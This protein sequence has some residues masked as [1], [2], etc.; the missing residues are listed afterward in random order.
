MPLERWRPGQRIRDQQ[1]IPIFAG[2]PP[3]VYT[4]YVGAFRGD[5]RLPV[6]PP[7]LSDGKD[8]LGCSQ[9]WSVRR[10][11]DRLGAALSSK[12]AG[13]LA[14]LSI[15]LLALV[16]TAVALIA[17]VR[18]PTTADWQEAAR[19][20]RA[21]FRPGDLVVAAP[22]WADQILRLHLGDLIPDD[23]AGRLDDDRFGRVW[24]ISQRGATAPAARRGA[25]VYERDAGRLTVRRVERTPETVDYDFVA[26]WADAQVIRRGAVG[27]AVACSNAGD[28]IQCPDVGYNFVRRQIVEVDT[29]LRVALLAQP[30]PNA[31]VVI[32][33]PQVPL[34]RVLV[35]GAGLHNVWMRKEA[36]GPVDIRVVIGD[37]IDVTYT[38]RNEDGW[39]RVRI[40]T[41]D[42]VGQVVPVRFEITSPSPYARHFA[43]AAEARR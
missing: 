37:R 41:A 33:Y 34:G 38:V 28:R 36:Q 14:V 31:A 24:E 32:E 17:P 35:L 7:A 25:L 27:P 42:L 9:L 12:R 5:Q 20:V 21:G 8:R 39:K 11:A 22:D 26:R 16:E 19:Q 30:V 18:A 29:R 2:A 13:S 1:R 6:D 43:F 40:D 15:V 4:M 23:V 10:P 3:G